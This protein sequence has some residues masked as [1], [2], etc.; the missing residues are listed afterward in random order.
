MKHYPKFLKGIALSAL[1]S[2]VLYGSALAVPTPTYPRL[3]SGSDATMSAT[4]K[5]DASAPAA[6]ILSR[7]SEPSLAKG[8]FQRSGASIATDDASIGTTGS[9]RFKTRY[10]MAGMVLAALTP[11]ALH[12]SGEPGDKS[13]GVETRPPANSSFASLGDAITTGGGHG[14]GRGGNGGGDNSGGD[15]ED[16]AGDGGGDHGSGDNGS[17]DCGDGNDSGGGGDHGGGGTS[18]PEPGTVPLVGAGLMVALAFR[19][20]DR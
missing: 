2:V 19:R 4:P 11:L 18:L 6:R 3:D 7:T 15:N 8:A 5:A 10:L 17:G 12:H 16:Q 9:S 1:A 14:H 20:R 13:V